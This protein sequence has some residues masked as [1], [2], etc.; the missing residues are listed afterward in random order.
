[1]TCMDRQPL[2]HALDDGHALTAQGV[3][4]VKAAKAR[5]GEQWAEQLLAIIFDPEEERE[6]P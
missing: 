6:E 2:L 4:L 5:Y 1:M 3:M